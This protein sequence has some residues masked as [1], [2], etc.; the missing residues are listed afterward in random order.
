MNAQKLSKRLERVAAYVPQNAVVADI[1]SDHAYLPCYLVHQGVASK[2]IA[3]EVVKGPY[4]SAC[5]EVK[6][7][8][9]QEK[10]EVRLADGME[11]V[12]HEDHVDTVTIAGMGGPLIAAILNKDLSRLQTVKRLILQPNI[13]A[14][15]IRTWAQQNTW[16]IIAEEIISEDEKIYEILVLERGEQTLTEAELLVGPYL[17]QE[18][19]DVFLA[20]W[21]GEINQ[22]ERILSSIETI[23]QTEAIVEKRQQLN[24][25][26]AIV[27]SVL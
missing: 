17:L 23:E 18:K 25:K 19:N 3:G 12:E 24:E 4:E 7:E 6:R 22:W 27:R 1:G 2:A 15:A 9:L 10:I 8:K 26:I 16:K 14:M 13:H 5:K 11:A 21:Q 20:K